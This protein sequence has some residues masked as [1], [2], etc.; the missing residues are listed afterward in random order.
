M[1]GGGGGGGGQRRGALK[2]QLGEKSI[3]AIML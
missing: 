1:G 2:V 3:C